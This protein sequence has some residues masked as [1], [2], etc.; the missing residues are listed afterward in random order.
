MQLISSPQVF[1]HT[2]APLC[3]FSSIISF[4]DD[5]L[6]L[7]SRQFRWHLVHVRFPWI[8]NPANDFASYDIK[9]LLLHPF[10]L[11]MTYVSRVRPS[12]TLT[13]SFTTST[14]MLRHN[15]LRFRCGLCP[16]TIVLRVHLRRY[17]VLL[18]IPPR[19]GFPECEG[20]AQQVLHA[21]FC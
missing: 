21:L 18:C 6:F 20:V 10:P 7:T 11:D 13:P 8:T 4:A 12:S 3:I 1:L 9:R 17:Y 5:R 16:L 14:R 15:T 2:I 19:Q